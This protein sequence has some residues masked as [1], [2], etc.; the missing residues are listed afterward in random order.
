M[1]PQIAGF[2]LIVLTA[3]SARVVD[4]SDERAP[5]RPSWLPP[6]TTLADEFDFESPA[7]PTC[8]PSAEM[9]RDWA[10]DRE[11]ESD[12]GFESVFG[13]YE[14]RGASPATR[15][16]IFGDRH[17]EWRL[18]GCVGVSFEVGLVRHYD[19]WIVL[20]TDHCRYRAWQPSSRGS[21]LLRKIGDRRV[22]VPADEIRAFERRSDDEDSDD[23][24]HESS[25][26]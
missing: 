24:L 18:H 2:S 21:Y 4:S 10:R 3:C 16:E 13:S 7:R 11:L 23:W 6:D 12:E 17:Y 25:P 26:E 14:T 19:D 8:Q 1:R 9:I 20:D 5:E 22:L 15:V